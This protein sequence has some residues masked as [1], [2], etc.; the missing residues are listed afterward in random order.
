MCSLSIRRLSLTPGS[1][2]DSMPLVLRGQRR[3]AS[4]EGLVKPDQSAGHVAGVRRQSV[5]Q[6]QERSLGSQHVAEIGQSVK[7]AIFGK[8]KRA[9]GR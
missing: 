5:L 9:P 3:T 8:F 7:I 4:S 2:R 6:R 1:V